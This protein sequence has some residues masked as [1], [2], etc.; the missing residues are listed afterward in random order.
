MASAIS[1][2]SRSRRSLRPIASATMAPASA[3]S[4]APSPPLTSSRMGSGVPVAL[5]AGSSTRASG[6]PGE[7]M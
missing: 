6:M 4:R 7:L 2:R 5:V 3:P 1:S